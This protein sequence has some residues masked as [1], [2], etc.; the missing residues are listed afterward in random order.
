[1]QGA[2]GGQCRV[3]GCTAPAHSADL[4]H[5]VPF[6]QGGP[7]H[8]DNL[9]HLCRRHHRIKSHGRLHHRHQRGPWTWTERIEIPGRDA[10]IEI[11]VLHLKHPTRC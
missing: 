1:M 7:T 9:H 5:V 8:A 3:A 11:D 2:Q 6:E 4:D 10:P